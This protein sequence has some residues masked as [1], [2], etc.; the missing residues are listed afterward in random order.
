MEDL[1]K[2]GKGFV[3]G[4]LS[5]SICWVAIVF[6]FFLGY[7]AIF[8]EPLNY[9]TSDGFRV[10]KVVGAVVGGI[11]FFSVFFSAIKGEI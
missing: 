4:T 5:F 10:A 7:V 3:Y 9:L 8:W 6:V 11:F 1:V 2:I